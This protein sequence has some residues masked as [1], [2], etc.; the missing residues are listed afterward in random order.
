M[1]LTRFLKKTHLKNSKLML[2]KNKLKKQIH[3]FMT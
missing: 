2:S 1:R 3:I